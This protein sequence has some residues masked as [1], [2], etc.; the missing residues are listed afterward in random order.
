MNV[1][2]ARIALLLF[3]LLSLSS[4][5]IAARSSDSRS[6][7]RINQPFFLPYIDPV[8]RGSESD[9]LQ[10][11]LRERFDQPN[12][13]LLS[14]RYWPLSRDQLEEELRRDSTTRRIIQLGP[15]GKP[16][17]TYLAVLVR[18]TVHESHMKTFAILRMYRNPAGVVHFRVMQFVKV[19]AQRLEEAM[20]RAPVTPAHAHHRE[21]S[22]L[23]PEDVMGLLWHGRG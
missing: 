5:C 11:H 10:K 21:G 22:L 2:F 1:T 23:S 20:E 17:H 12:A 6:L 9:R 8:Q 14:L 15:G 3:T 7:S 18:P 13:E 16:R 19:S 4:H